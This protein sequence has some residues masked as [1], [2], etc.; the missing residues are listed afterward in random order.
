MPSTFKISMK[1]LLFTLHLMA[2]TKKG[3]LESDFKE[4]IRIVGGEER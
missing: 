2:N 1:K 4:A 3:N